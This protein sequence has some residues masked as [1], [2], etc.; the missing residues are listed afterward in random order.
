M[1][2]GLY[3]FIRPQATYGEET[4]KAVF[5]VSSPQ[6]WVCLAR[7]TEQSGHLLEPAEKNGKITLELTYNRSASD[8]ASALQLKYGRGYNLTG[9]YH[10][11]GRENL[12]CGQFSSLPTVGFSGEPNPMQQHSHCGILMRFDK[13]P[14]FARSM[15]LLVIPNARHQVKS[16]LL[17][18]LGNGE[19]DCVLCELKSDLQAQHAYGTDFYEALR[20]AN[21][22]DDCLTPGFPISLFG[23]AA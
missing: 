11:T 6:K 3:Y 16:S 4:S 20:L 2:I 10:P 23:L 18:A 9:I 1:K 15:E 17:Q 22:T 7:N 5:G 13:R 12:A 19:L 14:T 21:P 8:L